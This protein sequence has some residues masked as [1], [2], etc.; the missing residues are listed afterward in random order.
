MKKFTGDESISSYKVMEENYIYILNALSK[1]RKKQSYPSM[2][3][4]MALDGLRKDLENFCK[5]LLTPVR[6]T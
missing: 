6:G 4:A 3:Y 5:W 1:D 2:E